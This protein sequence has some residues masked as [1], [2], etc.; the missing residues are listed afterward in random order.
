MLLNKRRKKKIEIMKKIRGKK[1]KINVN[2]CA[3]SQTKVR[4]DEANAC[5]HTTDIAGSV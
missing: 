3:A 2:F 4:V 1:E 5:A